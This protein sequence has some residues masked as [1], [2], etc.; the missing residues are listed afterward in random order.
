MRIEQTHPRSIREFK[1]MVFEDVVFDNNNNIYDI[2]GSI[3]AVDNRVT[4]SQSY[5]YQTPHP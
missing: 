3:Q 4:N 2:D 5:D 1:D